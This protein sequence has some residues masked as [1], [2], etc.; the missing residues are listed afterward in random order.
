MIGFELSPGR[1]GGRPPSA[2]PLAAFFRQ[3]GGTHVG[4]AQAPNGGLAVWTEVGAEHAA[5]LR[6]D[7]D[8]AGTRYSWRETVVA[9][10]RNV[11]PV[12]RMALTGSWSQQQT[13]GSGRS[14]SYTGNRAIS[15][16]STGAIA[17]VTVDRA[18]TYDLWINYTGRTSGAYVRVE[19]DGSQDLVNEIGDPAALGFKAFSTYTPSDLQR[20]QS[21]KVASGL[22]GAH[23]ITLTLGGAASPGGNT[24]MIEAVSI[25]G[26]LQD[27]HILPPLWTPATTY[28]MGDEVQF[29]G[30]FYAARANGVSGTT[31]P[32][33]TSGIASDGNLDWRA[34]N[35]PTYPEFVAIDYPSE[36]EYA[37]RFAVGGVVTELGG[38]TH[39]HEVLDARSISLDGLAWVPQTTGSGLSVGA[40]IAIAEDTTWQTG[41]GVAV[42]SCQLIRSVVPGSVNHAVVVTGTGAQMDVE[43]FYPGMLPMVRWDGEGQTTVVDSI[44]APAAIAVNL[45]DFAGQ[46]PSNIDFPGATRL[47]LSAQVNGAL[48]TYGHEAGAQGS[49]TVALGALSAFLRPNLDG[50]SESGND[51]WVAKA[52]IAPD[53]S[54]GLVFGNGDVVSFFNR[55]VMSVV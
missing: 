2:A 53:T 8:N 46:M 6:F 19:I 4:L 48:L 32:L 21:I 47:G 1:T 15:T 54:S 30:T 44:A 12:G 29:G 16:S 24:I 18:A 5:R 41:A 23:E 45:A 31:G 17:A 3:G 42:A 13:S 26:S 28:Q 11:Y 22:S 9:N 38:Q 27:P 14:G 50:R 40:Q 35:R 33:H 25:S 20:R 49:A 34:D 51:D 39:G 37:I 52:Y 7:N 43:W 55:H 10:L 36:R